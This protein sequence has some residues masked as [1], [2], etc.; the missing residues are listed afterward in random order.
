MRPILLDLDDTLIDDHAATAFAFAALVEAHHAWLGQR[1]ESEL[2]SEWRAVSDRHWFRY[3]Q[4]ELSYLE[5]RRIRAREFLGRDFT[6]AEADEALLPYVLAYQ[7]SWRLLPGVVE[8]FQRS[9]AIPKVIVT[10]GQREQQLRKL[11]ATDLLPHVVAVVTPEDCGY[12]KPRPEVFLAAVRRI[13]A[14]PG[15]CIMIGD[16]PVRDIAPAQELGMACFLVERGRS[17]EAFEGALSAA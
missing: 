15:S 5:Q 3:E 4:G 6:D 9:A 16:D 14:M 8:F 1:D 7:A 12:W 17:H 11:A 2:L 10:N 13:D